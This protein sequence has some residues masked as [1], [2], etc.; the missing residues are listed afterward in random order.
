[1]PMMNSAVI[2]RSL[3]HSN[4]AAAL[5]IQS[6]SYPPFLLED[7]GAFA[8]RLDLTASYCLAATRGGVLIAHLLAYGWPSEAPS[9]V[10]TI[11]S[12][13]AASEVLFIH[14][15]ASLSEAQGSGIGRTLATRA[16]ELAAQ[17]GLRNAQLIAVDG[18]ASY[19]Q[20]LGF[21]EATVADELATAVVQY[22]RDARWMTREI[23]S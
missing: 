9:P 4:L 10:G 17:E 16:F 15:L 2:V 12:P 7:E 18:A 6:Q 13:D 21:V 23:R 22:G 8:S 5:A 19:W 1:M 3:T 20:S 14:D 11:L